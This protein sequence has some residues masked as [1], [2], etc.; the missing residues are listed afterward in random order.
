MDG[1]REEFLAGAAGAV[2]D[3]GAV[4]RRHRRHHAI[5]IPHDAAATDD[6]AE[7]EPAL[8]LLLELFDLAEIAKRLDAPNNLA[9][10]VT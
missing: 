9:S 2:D 8:Q 4:A 5:K 7:R 1:A 10:A 6:V 3:D